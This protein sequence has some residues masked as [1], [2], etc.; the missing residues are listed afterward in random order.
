MN[1]AYQELVSARNMFYE[2]NANS[3]RTNEEKLNSFINSIVN[4][5]RIG[6]SGDAFLLDKDLKYVYDGS[7]DISIV[8]K[9]KKIY[10]AVNADECSPYLECTNN[11][12]QI[13]DNMT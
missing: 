11:L 3:T 2:I 9:D 7:P 8:L 13:A 12:K 1:I 10:D 6:D 4:K 5:L